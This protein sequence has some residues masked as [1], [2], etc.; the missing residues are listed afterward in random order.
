MTIKFELRRIILFTSNMEEMTRFYADVLG[1]EPA[2]QEDGWRDFRAGACNIALHDGKP[3][4]GNRPPKLV[5]YAKDVAA[6]R[7]ALIRR[8]AKTI[9]KV[10]SSATL[11]MC[12]GKDPDGNAFQ[13]STRQ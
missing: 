7:A 1:L 12:D 10:K 6:A 3:V 9:G 4:I 2:G 11:D 5:F 8:G 13:L